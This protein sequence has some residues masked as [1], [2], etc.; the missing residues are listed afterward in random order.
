MTDRGGGRAR[1][2]ERPPFLGA[3]PT[4]SGR[5]G[6]AGSQGSHQPG[7]PSAAWSKSGPRTR[8]ERVTASPS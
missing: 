4:L 7:D 2:R 5:P 1:L 3:S 6:R 8:K